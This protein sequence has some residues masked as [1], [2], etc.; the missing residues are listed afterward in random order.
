MLKLRKFSL[1]SQAKYC[2]GILSHTYGYVRRGGREGKVGERSPRGME[3]I[4][5]FSP[6]LSKF[7]WGTCVCCCV[8]LCCVVL[9]CVCVCVWWE[10]LGSYVTFSQIFQ[11]F[12]GMGMGVALGSY[13]IFLPNLSKFSGAKGGSLSSCVIFRTDK[14]F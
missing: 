14:F 11:N 3:G 5:C 2:N 12:P 1:I 4:I 6:N 7:S 13:V 9:C 8:V 10:A